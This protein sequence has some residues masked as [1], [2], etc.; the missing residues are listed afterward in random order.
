M[1]VD[2]ALL[3]V[4]VLRELF[5]DLEGAM[6]APDMAFQ[7]TPA[8]ETEDRAWILTRVAHLKLV[9]GKTG[10]AE[11]ALQQALTI[12]PGYPYALG[13][14]AKV[15]T[16]QQRYDEAAALEQQR[17]AA[18][19]GAANLFALAES[20]ELAGRSKESGEAFAQFERLSRLEMNLAAN[21]NHELAAYYLDHAKRP[22][23]ALRIA[24]MEFDRRQDIHT[25]DVY[26]RA[27]FANGR[28]AEARTQMERVLA[29][30]V[31]DPEIL[32]HAGRM[33]PVAEAE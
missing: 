29:G 22:E 33:R 31:R 23:E 25:L 7:S 6:M 9:Q 26:A 30:G 21:S 10:D 20:L 24:K 5:G 12:F 16:L 27:L 4:A 15:R 19:P 2:A 8:T 17:Y 18:A 1:P 32:R 28:R 11:R 3:R 14:L 13:H